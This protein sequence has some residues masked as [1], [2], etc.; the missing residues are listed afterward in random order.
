MTNRAA[1]VLSLF[2]AAL[3]AG[4]ALDLKQDVTAG[5]TKAVLEQLKEVGI[6]AQLSPLGNRPLMEAAG[7]GHKQLVEALLAKGADVNAQDITG[8]T[9]LHAAAYH[10]DPQVVQLLL[11][12]GAVITD[13]NW[14]TPAPVTVAEKMH[15]PE[16]VDLL[17]KAAQ[18]QKTQKSIATNPHTRKP[19]DR[20]Q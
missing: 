2:V 6:D 15:H 8:W 13:A 10:G 14:Y 5:D 16:A 11:D 17:K 4:C 19:T 18:E 1:C 7:H 9:P 20:L 12:H 3:V